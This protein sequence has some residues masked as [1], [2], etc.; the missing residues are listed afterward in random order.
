MTRTLQL[1]LAVAFA[2]ALPALAEACPTCKDQMASDANNGG[3]VTGFFWSILFM[4]SM[5]LLLAGGGVAYVVSQI[6]EAEV[7]AEKNLP[8]VPAPH[9]VAVDHAE[10]G[11]TDAA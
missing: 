8:Q 4:L 11:P 6:Y 7:A 3:L 9:A 2:L 5:P 1:A 10:Q